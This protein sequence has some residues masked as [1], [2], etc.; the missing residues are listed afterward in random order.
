MLKNVAPGFKYRIEEPF[1][2]DVV[3]FTDKHRN[4][5]KKMVREAPESKIIIT[6]SMTGE[7]TNDNDDMRETTFF[8]G[9]RNFKKKTVVITKTIT[10]EYKDSPFNLG[11]SLGVLSNNREGTFM[12]FNKESV[13]WE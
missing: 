9:R 2:D 10:S 8:L 4:V 5:L 11:L 1:G 3:D 13:P 6:H 12:V 7:R